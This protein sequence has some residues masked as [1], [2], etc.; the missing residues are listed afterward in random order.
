LWHLATH[1]DDRKR[2]VDDPQ[3]IP[4]AVEEFLRAYSR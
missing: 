3:L 2:L 4:T 1:A